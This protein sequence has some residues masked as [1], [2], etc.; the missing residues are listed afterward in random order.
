MPAHTNKIINVDQLVGHEI[1]EFSHLHI[2]HS[3]SGIEIREPVY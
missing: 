1:N 2:A 3:E